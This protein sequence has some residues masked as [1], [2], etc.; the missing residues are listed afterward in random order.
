MLIKSIQLR[1]S[2]LICCRLVQR[3]L[4]ASAANNGLLY[5]NV[6]TNIRGTNP[7]KILDQHKILNVRCFLPAA[8]SICSS[9]NSF[10]QQSSDI[11]RDK[12]KAYNGRCLTTSSSSCCSSGH[13]NLVTPIFLRA[14]DF[15]DKLA[16]VSQHGQYTYNDILNYSARLVQE[17]TKLL[18]GT[19][20]KGDNC[21]PRIAFLCEND[22]S[23]VVTQWAVFMA[24]CIAVP[25]C[26]QHPTNEMQYF[27]EDSG[28]SLIIGTAEYAEKVKPIAEDLGVPLMVLTTDDYTGEAEDATEWLLGKT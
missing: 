1:S 28:A 22:L 20:K 9:I 19:R 8:R 12:V 17:I 3:Y 26:K 13:E 2:N 25:L 10:L 16:V 14:Q 11:L 24:G 23:Y 7:S 5:P 18:K 15:G 27:V 6:L 21:N 4:S